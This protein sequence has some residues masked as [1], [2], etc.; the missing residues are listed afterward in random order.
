MALLVSRRR[1]HSR[2]FPLQLAVREVRR[3]IRL[4]C[5]WRFVASRDG[6]DA[7]GG[8]HGILVVHDCAIRAGDIF[9]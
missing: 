6:V 3:E 5:R 9:H 1:H 7:V 4:F 2:R 8:A